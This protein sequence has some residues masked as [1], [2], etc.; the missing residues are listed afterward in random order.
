MKRLSALV[1]VAVMLLTQVGYA[2]ELPNEQKDQKKLISLDFPGTP[3]ST[4]LDVL[5]I[6]TSHKF[7]TDSE[8]ASKRI[9]FNLKDV[10]PEEALNALLDTYGLYY[11]R[12]ADTNIYVI[13]SRSEA[14]VT[15]VSKVFFLNYSTGKELE[16]VLRT[17][18]T[19]GGSVSADE[20]TNSL[21]VTDVA[22]NLDKIESLI[23]AL[24][25]PTLQVLLEAKIVDVKIDNSLKFGTEIT[26]AYR[27]NKYWVSPLA[28]ER[29][30]LM[31]GYTTSESAV[32]PEMLYQ[33]TLMPS[34]GSGQFRASVLSGDYSVE[35]AIS[36]LKSDSTA[37]LLTNPRL[38]VMN[39]REATIDIIE[40]IPYS[41]STESSLSAGISKTTIAFK[42]VG[43]KL[44][45]KPQINR[46]GSIVLGIAPEQSF[47]TGEA[48]DGVPVI[49]TSR[50]NTTFV[51]KS[52][53][54]AVIGGLIKE[55]ESK[56]E[57]KIP[58]LGDIP[59]L[60]ILF[61]RYDRQ[62]VRSELTIFITA[63]VIQQ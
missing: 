23:K 51:I 46:D 48:L 53:E 47:R 37:R 33:Q 24:D 63:K 39:N 52:G 44:K 28:L 20:R 11:I 6:K 58:L 26:N 18:L 54:T 15:T 2:Y 31:S 40:Q 43:I 10:T 55:T 14:V 34:L 19:R 56:T 27:T 4:V 22:D 49:Y 32:M 5:S 41:Q 36:A 30:K 25:I 57:N 61:K 3:L 29:S 7:L 50:S 45:V 38:L 9:V 35:A 1:M 59:L 21:I 60:G 16:A 8:L 17:N 12:Q 13:K 62:K 42:D